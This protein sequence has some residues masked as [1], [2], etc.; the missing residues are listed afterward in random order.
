MFMRRD[1]AAGSDVEAEVKLGKVG[2]AEHRFL[3]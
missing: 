2:E 3:R 1:F